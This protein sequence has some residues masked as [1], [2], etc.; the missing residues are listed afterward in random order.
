MVALNPTL[1]KRQLISAY[2]TTRGVAQAQFKAWLRRYNP[3]GRLMSDPTLRVSA[4]VVSV[5]FLGKG[6]AY[7]KMDATESSNQMGGQVKVLRYAIT[8][9][10]VIVPPT[11]V[12]GIYKNPEGIYETNFSITRTVM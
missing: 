9:T 10:Y 3:F 2:R 4:Q 12:A 5:N 11:T 7:I 6:N 1:T 8:V